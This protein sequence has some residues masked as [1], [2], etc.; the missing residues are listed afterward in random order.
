MSYADQLR[1]QNRKKIFLPDSKLEVEIKKISVIDN[2]ELVGLIKEG[3]QEYELGP[4]LLPKVF[5]GATYKEEGKPSEEIILTNKRETSGNEVSLHSL[6]VN[7]YSLWLNEA[8]KFNVAVLGGLPASK[9]ETF[10]PQS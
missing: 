4:I 7:D 3:M 10:P 5:C 9:P 2:L 1:S 8:T 6:S